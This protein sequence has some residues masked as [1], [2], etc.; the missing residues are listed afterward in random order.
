MPLD[1][2]FP[3]R[4]ELPGRLAL[5]IPP[6]FVFDHRKDSVPLTT[7]CP[8]GIMTMLAGAVLLSLTHD[9]LVKRPRS[10]RRKH[11]VRD[12]ASWAEPGEAISHGK[13]GWAKP[14]VLARCISGFA[15]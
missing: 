11:A 2:I 10:H 3:S 6:A 14:L 12:N 15:P 8:Y 9:H 4:N 7:S 13:R 1:N 5:P